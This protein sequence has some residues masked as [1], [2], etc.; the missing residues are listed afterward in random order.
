[1]N[2]LRASLV[3]LLF[4]PSMAARA[5]DPLTFER[6]V[7]PILKAYCLD[8]HG[9]G[10][11]PKGMLDLRLK[12]TAEH[13]GES[14]PALV[15]G[16]P[17]E[18][19]L[20]ERIREGEMPPGEKKVPK[21]QVAVI[22]RWIASGASTAREEPESLP[23][24][25]GITA[26][27]RA[28]WAFQLVLHPEPP[29]CLPSDPI[30]SP[31]DAFLLI[32]LKER[33]LTFA[34]EA[35]RSTLIR[36]ASAD[37][38]GLPPTWAEVEAFV[39]DDSPDAYERMIDRLLES[40]HYGERWGRHWLD[41]AGYADSEGNG[42][43]DTPRPHAY[44]YR[45]YV[46]KAINSD[47]PL[48]RFLIE[49]LAADEMVPRPWTNLTPDQAETLAATGFLKMAPDGTAT[50]S[51]DEPLAA[52][53]V[54]ADAI[55][56]FGSSILGL[57]VACAQCHDHKYD[58]IPQA[59][60]F[61]LR[62]VL[63]PALDPQH[64]RR[65]VQRRISLYTDAD[66]AKAAAIDA[67]AAELSKA[68]AEKT[69]IFVDRAFE[70][71]LA[72]FPEEQ[73]PVLKAAFETP[74]KDRTDEQKALLAANPSANLSPG[75]LYQYDAASAEE[76][77]KDQAAVAAKVGEKPFEDFVSVLDEVPGILPET[78]IFHRGDYRRP[79]EAVNPGDLTIASPEGERF[80]VASDDPALPS[81]GRRLAYARHLVDGR[82]P[83]VGRV[84][85]N[86]IWLHHFGRGLVDTPG[87]FGVLG[88][89][90]SHPELL[91]W[92][93]SELV[94]RGWSLKQMHRLIM[95]SVAY[96]QSSRRDPGADSV[97]VENTLL[98][99]YPVRRLDAEVIRDRML[100]VSGK[101]DRTA[102]GPAVSVAEDT[103]GQVMPAGDSTRRSV[104]L[105]VKRTRPV[106]LLAAF[107]LPVMAVNCDRRTASTSAP[108]SLM[109]MNSDFILGQSKAMAERLIAETPSGLDLGPASAFAWSTAEYRGPKGSTLPKMIAQAW[110]L[111][112][113]RP[114]TTDELDAA[115]S[116][117]DQHLT[118]PG[119]DAP[120]N[121]KEL[122]AL[123]QLCQQLLSSNEFLY[124][125]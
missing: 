29:T 95:R 65:P 30:R 121:G 104:Y 90:P 76:L 24:G 108:Q 40:P 77:K 91:D 23:P 61:R 88:G 54:V 60:Y 32:K 46:I 8:C 103:V 42:S 5:D 107:D 78:K 55:K 85:A 109:L 34:P 1:M 79:T 15:A 35:D 97:D 25:L 7:R 4:L 20:L 58:P 45:D 47:K 50:G 52:N 51:A 113:Q 19:L 82:H 31:I 38:T 69:K 101:L 71:E 11:K 102:L 49:Q 9:A 84:V 80:E 28:F 16:Q 73:R 86:R 44:K 93:A 39:N 94:G 112:Y 70:K 110:L 43:D 81:S 17:V 117:V 68:L 36:R 89:R 13:G 99:H 111:A 59:D 6:D 22:E 63:E 21:D 83:M 2:I 33:G 100:A 18:S 123:T 48:D 72:K 53:Q 14:G 10:D 64:W 98:S 75:V 41:V 27:E 26:E 122:A 105:E 119:L 124:V 37:L 56:V 125:D 114:I 115:C 118:G 92:L 67:E 66:R 12:R 96:R 3:A 106:S 74:D 57:T 87:D 62:A 120:A 116:F